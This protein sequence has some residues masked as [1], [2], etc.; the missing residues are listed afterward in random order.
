MQNNSDY[1]APG[2]ED[3]G[4]EWPV[5]DR[6]RQINDLLNEKFWN[7]WEHKSL[8]P[9]E[10]V[11]C[12]RWCGEKCCDEARAGDFETLCDSLGE[13]STD[14]VTLV[15]VGTYDR[16]QS[17]GYIAVE[18]TGPKVLVVYGS[19][20]ELEEEEELLTELQEAREKLCPTWSNALVLAYVAHG[21][22]EF[23]T[24]ENTVLKYPRHPLIPINTLRNVAFDAARTR[25]VFPVDIDFVPSCSLR[26]T[27]KKLLPVLG[28]IDMG[29]FVVP[30]F[31][32]F[33]CD[34]KVE[35][36]CRF[37]D[38]KAA[39]EGGRIKPFHGENS[40]LMLPRAMSSACAV[41]HYDAT[42]LFQTNYYRWFIESQTMEGFYP[43]D[44]HI[45]TDINDQHESAI[46]FA[47]EP[48]IVVSRVTLGD[49]TP[50]YPEQFVGYYRNKIAWVTALRTQ[51]FKFFTLL[52]EFLTHVPHP[53]ARTRQE[54]TG[55]ADR[56]FDWFASYFLEM[57][58]KRRFVK[59][60]TESSFD[61]GLS[62]P[63]ALSYHPKLFDG[64]PILVN[65]STST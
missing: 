17:F 58:A 28:A 9:N 8:N 52:R 53:P 15:T 43:I 46:D 39:L 12:M 57:W 1:S 24:E 61:Q 14:E 34:D 37:E 30:Q 21:P 26:R 27:L 19:D 47:Y 40:Q 5:S 25:F 6:D 42:K 23:S 63:I 7:W 22:D 38:M 32:A 56:M 49:P 65:S 41:R 51:K 33:V 2:A 13:P 20:Y 16:L 31:V 45:P 36:P 18:W 29:A 44:V 11:Y 64:H 48:Y 54:T 10:T 4:A 35:V 59:S 50:R 3:T 55:H 60:P 62:R